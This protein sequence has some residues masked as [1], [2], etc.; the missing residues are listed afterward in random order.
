MGNWK[1]WAAP[2]AIV[3]LC[4]SGCSLKEKVFDLAGWEEAVPAA[5]KI[6]ETEEEKEESHSKEKGGEEKKE[7]LV[8][9]AETVDKEENTIENNGGTVIGYRGDVYYWKYT[10]ESIGSAGVF[11]QFSYNG[12][13]ENQ[14][15]R[16][17]PD[18]TEE[19]VLTGKGYG[20][21]YLAKGRLYLQD[22]RSAVYSVNIDGGDRIDYKDMY[23]W[24]ADNEAG[25]VIVYRSSPSPGLSVIDVR[26]GRAHSVLDG[27]VTYI[28]TID[29]YAYFSKMD[30]ATGE[31]VLYRLK[32]DG[33]EIPREIDRC[34]IADEYG[35]SSYVTGI[36]KLGNTLYYSYGY[37]AGTGGFFQNGGINS[38]KIDGT[39]HKECIEPGVISAEEFLIEQT[40]D[41]VL[42]Y[43]IGGG[44]EWT[45]SYIG[46]WEDSAFP[47]C[48]VKSMATG[49]TEQAAFPLSR[50]KSFVYLDGAISCIMENKAGYELMIPQET[51]SA[52][53]CG[54][55]DDSSPQITLIRNLEKVED[56]I[57]FT[58]ETSSRDREQDIGWRPGYQRVRS[59]FYTM[60]RGGDQPELI[61]SY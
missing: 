7:T 42:I 17:R 41:D 11:S 19:E 13:T 61:Y 26:S 20:D 49:Q 40:A 54:D 43:Y 2:A 1:R 34:F 36:T 51:A 9:S 27:V 3:L 32:T 33:T 45:G 16:R 29:G 60:E 30:E 47:E 35:S 37:Y 6:E 21:I 25:T 5:E 14:L 44:T 10:P 28:D 59:D 18:G 24:T 4:L 22:G 55:F 46:Y 12:E 8:Q 39:D 50:Q 38:V 52:L 53:G 31:L 15:I 58:V 48:Q 23:I 56:K 57:F